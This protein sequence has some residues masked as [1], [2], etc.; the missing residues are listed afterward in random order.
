MNYS[1]ISR[2]HTLN[3]TGIPAE[4][5]AKQPIHKIKSSPSSVR[6]APAPLLSVLRASPPLLSVIE[7]V[8]RLSELPSV[9]LES[10]E[11]AVAA[12]AD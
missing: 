2:Y 7:P 4:D 5:I 6:P 3:Q 11:A 1:M 8:V 10:V 12:V 9:Q